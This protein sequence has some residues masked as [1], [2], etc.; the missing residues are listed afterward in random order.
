MKT[1]TQASSLVALRNQ[2]LWKLLASDNVP[3][4]L[5]ILQSNLFESE[6]RLPASI[7][8]ER[9]ANDLAALRHA[10]ADLPRNAQ[11]YVTEWLVNGYVERR[12]L[13]GEPEEQYELSAAAVAAIRFVQ[14]LDTSYTAATESRLSLVIDAL[15][16]L[17]E[18]TDTDKAR[19]IT[20]LM[21]ERDRIDQE[22]A[23][24]ERGEAKVLPAA[25]AYERAKEIIALADD[26]I[27]DF[28]RVRDQFDHLHRDLRQKI[29]D[30]GPS[31]G[32]VLEA[33]FAG[34]DLIG[35]SPAGRSFL[36][37]WRL[38]TDPRESVAMDQALDDVLAREFAQQ[39]ESKDRRFLMNLMSTLLR[40]G[41]TVHDVFQGF[42]K[43]LKQFVASREYLEQ[44][45][46]QQAL[47]EAQRAALSV[48][49]QIKPG[50]WLDCSLDLTSSRI[51][52]ASQ[53]ALYDP[54][55]QPL[56][57]AM[58]VGRSAGI[59]LETIGE[60]VARSEIDFRSL[61]ED[62]LAILGQEGQASIA[63]VLQRFPAR[64][65]LGS[66]VG[67]LTLGV[68]H[69]VPAPGQ[70]ERVAW[71]GEDRVERSARIP[72]FYFSQEKAHELA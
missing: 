52:S 59:D 17:A 46:L 49:D 34:I 45:R 30:D 2:P 58:N 63:Q 18:D 21:A 66:V 67:L 69:G 42:A 26:L 35:E 20:R 43:S 14:S 61:Q 68:R 48:K 11:E 24:V 53:W 56:A 72:K 33:L 47:K 31:R 1:S 40:Q 60:L 16:R 70:V 50:Y 36:A 38:L 64:Q 55:T 12:F 29:L 9:V 71:I 57:A 39:L 37:F 25:T 13:P 7:L 15:V 62:I 3:Y 28:R 4:T 41:G 22:I 27:G 5:A 32:T 44:R 23:A 6:Q 54:A 65:G 10:G 8:H 51:R 19:R